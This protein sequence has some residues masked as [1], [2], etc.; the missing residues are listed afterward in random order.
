MEVV[1][2]SKL[3]MPT[4]NQAELVAA[5][6]KTLPDYLNEADQAKVTQDARNPQLIRI[7]IDSA[8][9]SFYSFE[10][11]VTY[12]DSREVNVEF[13]LAHNDNKPI[14]EGTEQVQELIKDYVRHIHECAQAL[15]KITHS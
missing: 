6:Q 11:N 13:R 4:L 14:E 9:R 5:W 1:V 3:D 2:L 8:G 7:H 15:Q 10:F 12:L